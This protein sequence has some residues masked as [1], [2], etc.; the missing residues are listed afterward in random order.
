MTFGEKL[1]SYRINKGM[2]QDE[3]AQQLGT[4]KQVISRYETNQRI[5]KITTAN[6]YA[7]KL[8]IPLEYLLNN[9]FDSPLT[10]IQHV[11]VIGNG[12][13]GQNVIT[14]NGGSQI[15]VSTPSEL[16]IQEK[17]LIRIYQNIT[18]K[19]QVEL[20]HYAYELEEQN[21]NL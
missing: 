7:E 14:D 12:N 6:E 21:L 9:S 2:S 5:P 18:P 1:K 11:S 10:S 8:N 3:L 15:K 17:E 16:S 13:A 20:L 4:T 19:Q